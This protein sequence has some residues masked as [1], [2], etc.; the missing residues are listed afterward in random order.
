MVL[1]IAGFIVLGLRASYVVGHAEGT[2]WGAARAF[3]SMRRASR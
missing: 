3:R 1:I 2:K